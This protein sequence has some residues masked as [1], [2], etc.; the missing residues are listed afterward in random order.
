MPLTLDIFIKKRFWKIFRVKLKD[1]AIE[2]YI[3]RKKMLISNIKDRI[4]NHK[5]N[6]Q[7]QK[8]INE[9]LI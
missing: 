7:K 2:K 6:K 3:E 8:I 1:K 4:S 9:F 5:N